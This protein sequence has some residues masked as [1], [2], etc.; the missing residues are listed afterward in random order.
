MSVSGWILTLLWTNFTY[1][2]FSTAIAWK[3]PILDKRNK[4]NNPFKYKRHLQ[5][6]LVKKMGCFFDFSYKN[7]TLFA[8]QPLPHFW[9][10]FR[11]ESPWKILFPSGSVRMLW[12]EAFYLEIEVHL[13]FE[14]WIW[15]SSERKIE[16]SYDE[17]NMEMRNEKSTWTSEILIGCFIVFSP[18]GRKVLSNN[19]EQK[20]AK[21]REV[22]S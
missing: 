11:S 4:N 16:W 18:L 19:N 22:C 1:F 2:R 9:F 10:P 8:S 13:L 12:C 20:C 15:K 5:T 14:N 21:E 17:I 6:P 3:Y 7:R